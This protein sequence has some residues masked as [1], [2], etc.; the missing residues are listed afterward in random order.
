MNERKEKDLGDNVT[1]SSG[2]HSDRS[3]S[4]SYKPL[5]PIRGRE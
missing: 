4:Q 5:E 2:D 1:T 3:I